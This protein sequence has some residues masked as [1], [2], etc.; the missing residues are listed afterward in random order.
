MKAAVCNSYGPPE[1][2]KI[3]DIEAPVIGEGQEDRVLI[4]VHHASVNPF[5]VLHRRGYLPVRPS[6]GWTTPKTKVL[7]IDVAGTVE[8]VGKGVSRFKAGDAVFGS[9]L[10]SHAE[11]VR[12]R[13]TSIVP[14][15]KNLSFQ[16]A[17]A[18]P[19][20]GLTAVQALRDAAQIKAGQRVLINGASGGI[21]HVAVQLARHF[22]AE[23]T[24]V[25][26]TSNLQWVKGLGADHVVDYTREDFARDGRKYDIIL[27]AVG[28]RT[29]YSCRPALT[30]TGVY[31]TEHPLQPGFQVF[32]LLIAMATGDKRMKA[33]LSETS[34]K[35]LA[36]L[37]GLA[38][39]GKL[40]PV[41]EQTYPLD[42]IAEAHCHVERGHTKGKV[43]V[44]VRAA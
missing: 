39:A 28:K 18:M 26:S 44:D 30:G 6:N 13:E 8:A 14:L 1:V 32:Q 15:P 3:E 20:V 35:D 31:V 40:R 11:F 17:A 25:T 4:R 37:C 23:V 7:G 12:V 19:C 33:H 38:E 29:Y 43:V 5:D 27:D 36:F 24:A 22:G 10:G 9:C 2:L 21:G 16:E 34:G 41:I 42:R